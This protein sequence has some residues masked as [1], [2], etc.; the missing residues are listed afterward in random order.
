VRCWVAVS[1]NLHLHSH[2]MYLQHRPE[3]AGTDEADLYRLAGGLTVG[4]LSGEAR[5]LVSTIL[6]LKYET[7]SYETRQ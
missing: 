7:L 2:Y 3:L 6:A 5:H 4:K 1:G